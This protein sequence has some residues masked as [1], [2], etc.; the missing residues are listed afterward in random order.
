[1]V[2]ER[3]T[4]ADPRINPCTRVRP[5]ERYGQLAESRDHL[6]RRQPVDLTAETETVDKRETQNVT[7]EVAT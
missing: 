1:M 5:R 7:W 2:G 3:K 4:S 6:Q